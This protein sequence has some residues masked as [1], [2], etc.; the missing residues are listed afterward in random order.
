MCTVPSVLTG[1]RIWADEARLIRVDFWV[2]KDG[3]QVRRVHSGPF[4]GWPAA[5]RRAQRFKNQVPVIL[6]LEVHAAP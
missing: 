6:Q 5:E 3:K 4:T 1:Y 2:Y